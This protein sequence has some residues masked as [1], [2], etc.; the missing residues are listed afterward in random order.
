MKK[1]TGI[2]GTAEKMLSNLKNRF[3]VSN[4]AFPTFDPLYAAATLLNPPYHLLLDDLQLSA[5]KKIILELMCEI[6][7]GSGSSNDS[8]HSLEFAS[9]R[10]KGEEPPMKRFKHL[11]RVSSL[12]EQ[13]EIAQDTEAS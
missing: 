6:S 2:S 7:T 1:I 4:P 12:I 3:P 9:V 5:S 10:V 13:E 11:S 8:R